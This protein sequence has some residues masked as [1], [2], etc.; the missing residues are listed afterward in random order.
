MGEVSIFRV[1]IFVFN[2]QLRDITTGKVPVH[3]QIGNN[4][5]QNA[6][7]HTH[8]LN[9]FQMER[10]I[11]MLLS[12]CDQ[13]IIALDEVRENDIPIIIAI[14]IDYAKDCVRLMLRQHGHDAA[15]RAE[16]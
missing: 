9:A 2:H 3:K 6:I 4:F 13:A 5:T 14:R 12:K 7:P 11:Q 1:E 15:V 16:Q 10:I 8:T